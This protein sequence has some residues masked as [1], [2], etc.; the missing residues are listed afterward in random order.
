MG[1]EINRQSDFLRVKATNL[2]KNLFHL[3]RFRKKSGP[4]WPHKLKKTVQKQIFDKI[5]SIWDTR[6]GNERAVRCN[7]WRRKAVL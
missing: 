1:S 5:L 4:V 2:I 7:F 3:R 6:A